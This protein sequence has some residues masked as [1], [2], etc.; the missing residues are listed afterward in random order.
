[1]HESKLYRYLTR[2]DRG[3][4]NAF[5]RYV[6]ALGGK[7]RDE[8]GR[9]AKLFIKKVVRGKAISREAFYAAMDWP[10]PFNPGLLNHRLTDLKKKLDAFLAI[11]ALQ[12]DPRAHALWQL[13]GLRIRGWTDLLKS[14]MKAAL[15]TLE[16]APADADQ[17]LYQMQLAEG[18]LSA[19]M[20]SAR[21]FKEPS[22]QKPMQHL[23]DYFC[24]QQ[25]RYAC[26]ALTLDRILNL[27]HD[28]GMLPAVIA[29]LFTRQSN[30]PPLLTLYLHTF[31]ML[32]E[33]LE[34]AHYL[35]L[36]SGL[37]QHWKFVHPEIA[38][39]L[40]K[41]LLNHCAARINAGDTAY[42]EE[43]VRIYENTLDTGAL[44]TEG[45][46]E[47][48]QLKNMI[49]M[50]IRLG[51]L[52]V[53]QRLLDT[54]IPKLE[55]DA[56]PGTAPYMRAVLLYHQGQYSEAR[57]LLEIVLRDTEDVFF[58]VDA[59]LFSWRC[60]YELGDLDLS[61]D[62][63]NSVRMYLQRDKLLAMDVRK[64]YLQFATYL[65]RLWRIC[66]EEPRMDQRQKKLLALEAQLQIA[67]NVSNIVWLREKIAQE[68][69][70]K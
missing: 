12:H 19:T 26:A 66:S 68:L 4:Q 34:N 7:N 59:R 64:N 1:M 21:K 61:E 33:P 46:I 63:F 56:E 24:L 58:K 2:L 15:E 53:A 36:R 13:R 44:L 65:H 11:H 14:E 8:L 42:I 6:E 31:Q 28:Y 20:E 49:S 51:N 43:I 37:E 27:Q 17:F 62:N 50:M 38:R 47:P 41:Y 3:E 16:E 18:L 55:S 9:M 22:F 32:R 5:V 29:H 69:R 25:L 54:Y 57:K 60:S 45:K 30:L 10:E 39:E 23:E 52:P 40:Y 48:A 35:A 67:K 70:N